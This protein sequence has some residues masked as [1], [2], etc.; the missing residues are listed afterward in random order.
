MVCESLKIAWRD[1]HPAISGMWDKLDDAAKMAID[2][3]GKIFAAN[4]KIQFAANVNGTWLFMRVPSGTCLCY[5]LPQISE[6]GQ[7][8]YMGMNQYSR[9][10]QRLKTYGG[11]WLEH[12]CQKSARDV[13]FYNKP[14]IE[15]AGY[16]IVLPVHDEF[17]TE[18]PDSDEYSVDRLS[19]LMSANKP[20]STG[21]PLAA[22]GFE[23]ARYRKQ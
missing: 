13:L 15:E 20:W 3:P 14:E 7:V 5:P 21:L 17:I 1:A 11:K 23:S 16:N 22:A 12:G 10:W 2:N 18:V 9:K 6:G 19:E 8:T 4:D